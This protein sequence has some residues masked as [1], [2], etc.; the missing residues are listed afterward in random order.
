MFL[1]RTDSQVIVRSGASFKSENGRRPRTAWPSAMPSSPR[2]GTAAAP[3][4]IRACLQEWAWP[5]W[6]R[7]RPPARPMRCA[8]GRQL[9][10][11]RCRT[12]RM[13]ARA[14]LHRRGRALWML[15]QVRPARHQCLGGAWGC[16]QPCLCCAKDAACEGKWHP[17][18]GGCC[19]CCC[20]MCGLGHH[21]LENQTFNTEVGI[22]VL[23]PLLHLRRTAKLTRWFAV[24]ACLPYQRQA[25]MQV[26]GTWRIRCTAFADWHCCGTAG[27]ADR[28][29]EI[30]AALSQALRGSYPADK[31]QP[32][33]SSA[34]GAAGGNATAARNASGK[35]SMETGPGL[36]R[37]GSQEL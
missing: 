32:G 20:S 6:L 1:H 21:A 31:S 12:P 36:E 10:A 23:G 33:S 30:A 2:C 19:G 13:P 18:D 7:A 3:A 29:S 11:M 16:C 34:K 25:E 26:S 37:A 17:F 28:S 14:R 9:P 5:T 15:Q 8:R 24:G 4:A 35:A 22:A 27:A